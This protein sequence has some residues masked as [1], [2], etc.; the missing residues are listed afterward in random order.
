MRLLLSCFMFTKA[1][2]MTTPLMGSP[3]V[4]SPVEA[5]T[6]EPKVVAL[7]KT[8]A[9]RKVEITPLLVKVKEI[10]IKILECFICI[11]DFLMTPYLKSDGGV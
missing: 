10:S 6:Y 3:F 5:Y 11:T 7:M 9:R 2:F 8:I 4:I 1:P